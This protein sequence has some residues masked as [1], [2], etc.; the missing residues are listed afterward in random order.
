MPAKKARSAPIE[1]MIDFAHSE[2]D[3]NTT[4]ASATD[5]RNWIEINPNML[6]KELK[7]SWVKVRDA[8]IAAD[9]ARNRLIETIRNDI[10]LCDDEVRKSAL[11]DLLNDLLIEFSQDD[12]VDSVP[13][14]QVVKWAR[15]DWKSL[16]DEAGFDLRGVFRRRAL[17]PFVLFPR[18]VA[19]HHGQAEKLPIYENLRQAHEAFVFGTPFAALALMR[20]IMEVVLRDHYRA[21]GNDLSE[22]ISNSKKLL[23][24][25]AEQAALQRCT[26]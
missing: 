18:H 13:I 11:K 3:G 22:R 17:V 12:D 9:A 10:R 25:G 7:A 16:K 23:P 20:S 26:A 4:E 14:E 19:A 15:A 8:S 24:K 5:T 21:N 1:A 2:A 6:P